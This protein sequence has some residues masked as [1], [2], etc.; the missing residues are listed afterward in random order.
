VGTAGEQRKLARGQ[1]LW[2]AAGDRDV[3]VVLQEPGSQ[4]FL[5]SDGLDV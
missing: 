4:V 5:A 1:A 3:T 2:L